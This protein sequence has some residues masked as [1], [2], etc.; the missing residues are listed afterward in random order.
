MPGSWHTTKTN[1]FSKEYQEVRFS[2]YKDDDKQIIQHNRRADVCFDETV[3]E[4]Q[5]SRIT[6]EEVN[7]RNNDYKKLDKKVVWILDCTENVNPPIKLSSKYVEEERWLIDF[8]KKWHIK[9]TEECNIVYADF[10]DTIFRVPTSLIKQRMV[11]TGTPWHW[12]DE[13]RHALV[14]DTSEYVPPQST[15]TVRQDPHGSG[16]TYSLTHNII[17]SEDH[18][19]FQIVITKSHAAKQVVYEEFMSHMI[20]SNLH[21]EENEENHKYIVKFARTNGHKVMCIFGTADSLIYNICERKIKG[22]DKFIDLVKSVHKFGPTKLEGPKGRFRYAGERPRINKKTK[23]IIDEGTLLGEDYANAISTIMNIC[24]CD[25]HLAGDVQQSVSYKRNLLRKIMEEYIEHGIKIPFFSSNVEVHVEKGNKVRRFNQDLVNFRNIVMQKFIEQPSH[26]LQIL[27]PVAD[28]SVHH[29]RGIYG[30]ELIDKIN[31][32]DD[33]ESD[34]IKDAV[35]IIMYKFDEDVTTYNKLPNELMLVTVFVNNNPLMDEIQSKIHEYWNKK[36]N[37]AEWCHKMKNIHGQKFEEIVEHFEGTKNK[38]DWKCVFHRSE[39]G[40]PIDTRESKYATRIVSIHASQGDGR[41]IAYV[42]G[43]TESALKRFSGGL[44]DIQYE[45]LLNVAI[46]RMKEIIRVFLEK[47][48]DDIFDRFI[49]LM[50]EEMVQQVAPNLNAKSYFNIVGADIDNITDDHKLYNMVKDR[51]IYNENSEH[52]KPLIDYSHHIIRMAV[53]NTIIHANLLIRQF[54]RSEISEQAT[55]IFRIFANSKIKSCDSKEYYSICR[56]SNNRTIPV[57]FYNDGRALFRETHNRII[58]I[59]KRLQSFVNEWLSGID[60]NLVKITPEDAVVLQYGIE[61]V[62]LYPIYKEEVKMD[63]VYDVVACY[64]NKNEET[65]E[66]LQSHYDHIS[67]IQILYRNIIN[68]FNDDWE[69]K[70]YRSINLG[71]KKNGQCTQHFV[72]KSLISH[73]VIDDQEAIPILFVPDIDELNI[74]KICCK[75]LLYTLVCTQPEQKK[76]KDDT[77]PTWKYVNN[78]NIKIC[79]APVKKTQPIVVDVMDLVEDNIEIISEWLKKYVE[80]LLRIDLP[81]ANKIAEYY[82]DDLDTAR[83][84]VREAYDDNDCPEY[85]YDAF[86]D[87]DEYDEVKN[88]LERQLK[89]HLKR[90]KTDIRA[91]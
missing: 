91:R 11:V 12:D 52:D 41:D 32:C 64:M 43:L 62:K 35:E 20:K 46:S 79:I 19:D 18:Y 55:T 24:S 40:K 86:K 8:E 42:I 14:S 85:M 68:N 29:V 48:H 34:E 15:L 1:F 44:I 69:W 22:T 57:L 6:L 26:N 67:N 54:K 38:L 4:Y 2:F 45:S 63:H 36:F 73:L 3:I 31:P 70:I 80:G 28:T 66:K 7:S 78:K 77:T 17:Y 49:P 58:D 88:N 5:H 59:L 60:K 21:Y 61:I 89:K 47:K 39:E 27:T 81:Q 37:D 56:K 30:V 90:F 71:N 10:G 84:T 76:S 82:R 51:V 87:S 33:A 25:V 72:L 13:F 9:S 16:K 65:P 50:P 75:V 53:T 83:N 23:I 74:A